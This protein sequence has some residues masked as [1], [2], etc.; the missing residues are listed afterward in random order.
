[1]YDGT[2]Y[3]C[4]SFTSPI[5]G[6]SRYIFFLHED[7]DNNFL[8]YAKMLKDNGEYVDTLVFT[9]KCNNCGTAVK[10]QVEAQQHARKTRHVN[11]T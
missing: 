10:G 6:N 8:E 4:G 5:T 3:N 7:Y 11:Y 9:L 1:M 2:H